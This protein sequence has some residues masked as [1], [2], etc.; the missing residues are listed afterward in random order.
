MSYYEQLI[1]LI[2]K[3]DFKKFGD[4]TFIKFMRRD[5]LSEYKNNQYFGSISN[6][7]VITI[8]L[9]Q[10]EDNKVLFEMESINFINKLY[11]KEIRKISKLLNNFD[12]VLQPDSCMNIDYK[13]TRFIEYETFM[14][15]VNNG[16]KY[17]S[18]LFG[19]VF[20]IDE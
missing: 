10:L 15:F 14:K 12:S 5:Y 16:W 7:A 1:E 17:C 4:S 6:D 8:N 20:N 3:N 11:K 13:K 9:K 18:C 2:L 19:H